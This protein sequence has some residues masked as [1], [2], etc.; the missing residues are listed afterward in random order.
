MKFN[1]EFKIGLIAVITIA[2]FIWLF[3]FLKGK[4]VLSSANYYYAVY[5]DIGGLEEASPVYYKG[6]KVGIVENI[7]FLENHPDKLLV[8]FTVDNNV[9]IPTKSKA[10]IYGADL[11]GTKAIKLVFTNEKKFHQKKDTLIT[12]LEGDLQTRLSNEIMPLKDKA[13]NLISNIDSIVHVVNNSRSSLHHLIVNLENSSEDLEYLMESEKDRLSA[14]VGNAKSITDNIENNNEQIS[15]ILNNFANVSDS[16]A[17]ANFKQTLNKA[18]ET[19]SALSDITNKINK[20]EGSIGLLVNNDSLYNNLNTLSY[21]LDQ[22]IIDLN[23]NPKRYVHF[24]LFG[25][26]NK[27][28]K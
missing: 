12:A 11:L 25:K 15:T 1:R 27:E 14:I 17:A 23:E 10:V 5:D 9:K 3:N 19:L 26:K 20:G 13:E 18:E 2:V 4:N 16:L 7:N 21:D 8:E 28:E 22:L 6:Y 24:S